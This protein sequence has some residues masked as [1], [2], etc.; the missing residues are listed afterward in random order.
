M[1]KQLKESSAEDCVRAC[2]SFADKAM[3]A[4]F[5]TGGEGGLRTKMHELKITVERLA[6]AMSALQRGG[7]AATNLNHVLAAE[8]R[9]RYESAPL[10]E[11]QEV[12]EK[13]VDAFWAA[14][15]KIRSGGPEVD[16]EFAEFEHPVWPTAEVRGGET[17]DAAGTP[18]PPSP[19]AHALRPSHASAN[20]WRREARELV[21]GGDALPDPKDAKVTRPPQAPRNP[22]G[23]S[24]SAFA[25]AEAI[26][27]TKLASG[28]LPFLSAVGPKA[29]PKAPLAQLLP[30]Q[31]P[32]RDW[33]SQGWQLRRKQ[34]RRAGGFEDRLSKKV[35]QIFGNMKL[36]KQ[37]GRAAKMKELKRFKDKFSK[38]VLRAVREEGIK[39]ERRLKEEKRLAKGQ[40]RLSREG[41]SHV[42]SGETHRRATKFSDHSHGAPSK[43][44]DSHPVRVKAVASAKGEE[45]R[46]NTIEAENTPQHQV[47]QAKMALTRDRETDEERGAE[48]DQDA[49]DDDD[50]DEDRDSEGDR[51]TEDDRDADEDQN[52]D[53]DQGQSQDQEEDRERYQ[54][55]DD[56]ADEDRDADEDQDSDEDSRD[57]D[58][59]GADE[60]G[61]DEEDD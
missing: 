56:G 33:H 22:R 9:Q 3:S 26:A 23:F 31:G 37:D 51:D 21:A 32:A 50:A 49:K 18:L 7:A 29:A 20:V 58:N 8:L 10:G 13:M 43:K 2:E 53:E 59:E 5:F 24:A 42:S 47:A 19:M 39:E 30:A 6:T 45:Q 35:D 48:D 16:G 36:Q 38:E 54:D 40:A 4:V 1:C 34:H 12:A 15:R 25:G 52:A 17:A 27:S 57:E 11:I 61:G 14:R 46:H 28:P 44:R 60:D 55:G 41:W